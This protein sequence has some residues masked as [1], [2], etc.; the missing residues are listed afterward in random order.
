[1]LTSNLK[2]YDD[3]FTTEWL[4]WKGEVKVT[5]GSRISKLQIVNIQTG[6]FPE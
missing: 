1:M 5:G 4:I 6:L 2:N 3:K